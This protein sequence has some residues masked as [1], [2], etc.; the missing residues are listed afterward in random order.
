LAPRR[1]GRAHV[2]DANE[3]GEGRRAL[4][5][6]RARELPRP[7]HDAREEERHDQEHDEHLDEREPALMDTTTKRGHRPSHV[8]K[9]GPDTARVGNVMS[10][11][12]PRCRSGPEEITV[13]DS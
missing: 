7:H 3:P 13:V 12:L 11:S 1:H 8:P 5:K 10:S 6:L 4:A 2:R 9:S